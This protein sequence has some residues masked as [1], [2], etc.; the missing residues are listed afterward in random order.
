[1]KTMLICTGP[2]SSGKTTLAGDLAQ[3]LEA[4]LVT[5]QSRAYLQGRVGY[6]PSDLLNIAR[7]QQQAEIDAIRQHDLVV[8]DTDL[9]VIRIWW[10]EKYGPHPRQLHQPVFSPDTLRRVYLLCAP[11]MAW[12]PDPLRENPADRDRLF[13]LYEQDCRRLQLEFRILHGLREQRLKRV[14]DLLAELS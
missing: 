5:E 2:E 3:E 12:Q 11:D 10:R 13:T 4:P 8:A 7:L 6:Q 9:Q 14:I 1:M